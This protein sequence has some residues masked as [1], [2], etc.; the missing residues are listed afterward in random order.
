MLRSAWKNGNNAKTCW[1]NCDC[2][3]D[4]FLVNDYSFSGQAEVLTFTISGEPDGRDCRCLVALSAMYAPV[5]KQ[6]ETM[7]I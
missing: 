1:L 5:Q 2:L 7:W 6:Q 3:S 4:I